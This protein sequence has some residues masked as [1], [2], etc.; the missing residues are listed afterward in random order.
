MCRVSR[1]APRI[2]DAIG[3]QF[4]RGGHSPLLCRAG[5]ERRGL[6]QPHSVLPVVRM[7]KDAF[8]RAGISA[9]HISDAIMRC[10]VDQKEG[11]SA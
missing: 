11:N 8:F 6:G 2:S 5:R 10:L 7:R 9:A 4:V 1:H 3:L